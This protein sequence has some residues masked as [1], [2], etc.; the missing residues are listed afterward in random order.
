MLSGK[1]TVG[2]L[3]LLV[4]ATFLLVGVLGF[5]PGITTNYGDLS[6]NDHHSEAQLLGLFQVSVLHNVVHILFGIAGLMWWR[7]VQAARAYLIGGGIV[8]LLLGLYGSAIEHDSGANFVPVNTADNL[9]HFGLGIAMVA[10]GLIGAK[11][12]D[13]MTSREQATA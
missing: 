12:I 8:Y 13:S 5:V 6:F 2:I 11:V 10:L 7:T 4:G 9:L 3:A 1:P